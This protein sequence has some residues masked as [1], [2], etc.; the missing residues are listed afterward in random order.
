MNMM[1]MKMMNNNNKVR[2][3]KI[4]ITP[5]KKINSYNN[6]YNNLICWRK[7]WILNSSNSMVEIII[8]LIIILII[9]II[10][11]SCIFVAKIIKSR[12][13]IIFNRA[14][15]FLQIYCFPNN[16]DNTFLRIHK[17]L[18]IIVIAITWW[19]NFNNNVFILK[20]RTIFKFFYQRKICIIK[21]IINL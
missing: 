17:I 11:I 15:I 18:K 4:I 3:K 21:K 19:N 6:Y 9:I 14:W 7:F 2:I 13:I 16:N 20:F 10:I 12:V 1:K 5:H 8:I